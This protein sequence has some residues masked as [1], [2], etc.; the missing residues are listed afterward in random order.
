MSSKGRWKHENKCEG[1]K[2]GGGEVTKEGMREEEMM[3]TLLSLRITQL[4]EV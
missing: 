4:T 2:H 1:R 3:V